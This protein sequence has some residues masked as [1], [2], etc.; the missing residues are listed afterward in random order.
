VRIA[1][2]Y[3]VD[4]QELDTRLSHE[5]LQALRD[6]NSVSEGL[7]AYYAHYL[8]RVLHGDLGTSRLMQQSVRQLLAERFPETLKSVGYGLAL[9]W[10]LGLALAIAPLLMRSWSADL[11][12]SLM[13]GVLLCVPAA[14]LALLFII[15]H[16]PGRLV[17]GLIVFP[18]VFRYARNLLQHSA[19][20]PHV[21]T[22][23]AKGL[24]G[25][26]I[27]MRHILPASTAQL[28]ALAGITVSMAFAAAIP[29]EVICDLP[30]VGQLAWKAALGRDMTLLVDLTLI[31][32]MITLLA[33]SSAE[34]IHPR[35][36]ESEA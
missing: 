29:V 35:A 31:V 20:Q 12:S 34:L 8:N 18:K 15:A 30:G 26:R 5:S 16:A 4:E 36:R 14:M 25:F 32:T 3:G 17:L 21:L 28:L 27:F 33:N 23:W 22:A 9:G 1:P 2:G 13:A 24:G 6:S 10:T 11:L 19:A 7:A